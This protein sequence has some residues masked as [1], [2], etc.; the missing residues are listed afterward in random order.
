MALS[1]AAQ[2]AA[3]HVKGLGLGCNAMPTCQDHVTRCNREMGL[4]IVNERV[5]GEDHGGRAPP[6][7][8]LVIDHQM[9]LKLL[10]V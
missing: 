2:H 4:D 10:N 3:P 7:A 6:L 1:L 8:G 5:Y 9:E